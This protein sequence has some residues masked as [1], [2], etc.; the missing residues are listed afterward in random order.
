MNKTTNIKKNFVLK[1]K[2]L[3][4]KNFVLKKKFDFH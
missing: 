2:N 3:T 1:K 4:K